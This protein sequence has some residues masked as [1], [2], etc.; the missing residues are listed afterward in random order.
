MELAAHLRR[1]FPSLPSLEECREDVVRAALA[2]PAASFRGEPAYPD[3]PT[4][5][6]TMLYSFVKGHP[7]LDGN[8]RYGLALMLAFLEANGWRLEAKEP[9]LSAQVRQVA[10][11]PAQESVKAKERFADWIAGRVRRIG[12]ED[13]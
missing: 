10:A 8:K 3:V 11:S 5:A 2:L 12:V 1:H 4:Q 7:C 6:A 9:Q 13:L